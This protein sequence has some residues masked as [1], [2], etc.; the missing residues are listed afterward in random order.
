MSCTAAEP[1]VEG[2][3][4]TAETPCGGHSLILTASLQGTLTQVG[5][6]ADTT[7]VQK[8]LTELTQ[9]GCPKPAEATYNR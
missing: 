6:S 1:A 9:H 4:S 7:L 5:T 3:L 2:T 8:H